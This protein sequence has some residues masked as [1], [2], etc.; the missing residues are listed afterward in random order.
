MR[1]ALRIVWQQG[2]FA[3][4]VVRK[5]ARGQHHPASRM[6]PLFALRRAHHGTAH[7]QRI[8]LP[9]REQTHHG[10]VDAQVHAGIEGRLGQGGDQGVAIDQLHAPAMP[11]QVTHMA[12]NAAGDVGE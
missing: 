2:A 12:H 11:E 6:H 1:V 5:A 7:A 8:T 3:F 10:A 9:L 4:R